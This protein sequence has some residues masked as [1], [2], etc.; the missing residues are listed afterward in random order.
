M[1]FLKIEKVLPPTQKTLKEARG[2]VIA[3]Y[4]DFLEKQWIED[5]T[6]SYRVN[7]DRNVLVYIMVNDI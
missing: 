1:N 5:L 7:I 2:F 6:N 3:D 4:Q